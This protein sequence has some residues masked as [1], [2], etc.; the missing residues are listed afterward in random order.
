MSFFSESQNWFTNCKLVCHPKMQFLTISVFI[1]LKSLSFCKSLA[2]EKCPLLG[3][4]LI[5]QKWCAR[6]FHNLNRTNKNSETTIF[7]QESGLVAKQQKQFLLLG[8][9]NKNTNW[10]KNQ[11][12][13]G[14]KHY[15]LLFSRFFVA[16]TLDFLT[17]ASFFLAFSFLNFF[18]SS[19]CSFENQVCVFLLCFFFWGGGGQGVCLVLFLVCF[20]LFCF[21]LL[22]LFFRV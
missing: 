11:K 20:G 2:F 1:A 6:L 14:Q 22:L 5:G 10:V 3:V 13:G 12:M 16:N 15:A 9:E 19:W 21:V 18:T 4:S 8:S 17:L 7:L